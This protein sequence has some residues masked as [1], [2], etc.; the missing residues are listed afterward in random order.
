[1]LTALYGTAWREPML[2]ASGLAFAGAVLVLAVMRDGMR[3]LRDT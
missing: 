1:L 3:R 2:V